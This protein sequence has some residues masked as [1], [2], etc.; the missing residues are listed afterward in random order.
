MMDLSPME[1]SSTQ[2]A[3]YWRLKCFELGNFPGF[4]NLNLTSYQLI[5]QERFG[6]HGLGNYD[7]NTKFF[8]NNSYPAGESMLFSMAEDELDRDAMA[9]SNISEKQLIV[10]NRLQK[11][12][13]SAPSADL[14]AEK[15]GEDKT[16][17]SSRSE[18]INTAVSWV[19]DRCNQSCK[20]GMCSGQACV[21]NSGWNGDNCDQVEFTLRQYQWITTCFT[22]V[23]TIFVLMGTLVAWKTVL[24][25][26]EEYRPVTLQKA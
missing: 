24:K 25:E 9:Q 11:S 14:R 16:L 17:R 18:A 5:C 10:F 15:S 6:A 3:A 21:C 2:A 23:P 19:I 20:N 1:N 22:L 26:S 7:Q 8:Y 4:Y 12:T 13:I